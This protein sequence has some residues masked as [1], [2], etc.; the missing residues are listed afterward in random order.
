MEQA[1]Q[2]VFDVT[3]SKSESLFRDEV[4]NPCLLEIPNLLVST[5]QWLVFSKSTSNEKRRLE[6]PQS[7]LEV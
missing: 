5:S 7:P 2:N 1:S 6:H 3:S 4:E